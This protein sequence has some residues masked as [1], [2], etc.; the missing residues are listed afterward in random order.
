MDPSGPE[1]HAEAAEQ[2]LALGVGAG[3]G[4]DHD[5]QSLDLVDLVEVDLREDHLLPEPERVVAATVEG[6]VG[7]ALEVAHP[8]QRGG[9]EPVEELVHAVAPQ[10][11]HG[12]DGHPLA[13]LEVRDR[14]LRLRDHRLLAG[15]GRQL[16][17]SRLDDL[18]VLDRLAQPHVEDDLLETRDRH[19]V[20]VAEF[21]HQCGSDLGA[22]PFAQP[23]RHA[24]PCSSVSPQRRH[25]RTPRPS[26]RRRWPIRAGLL[27]R[28]QRSTTL[29]A[30]SDAS[31][32]TMPPCCWTPRGFTWRF[33]RFR[34][35]ITTRSLSV[36]T[37]RILPVLPRSRP[38]MTITVS[39]L[40]SRWT[41]IVTAPRARAR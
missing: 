41:A 30:W 37:R 33:T 28:P 34:R 20:R 32:S 4:A 22:V 2:R 27:H 38:A 19:G 40:R 39:F 36:R 1:R 15:D 18:R 21:A 31:F 6:A 35:S 17:H 29:E 25:T 23:G 11:H 16:L 8:G 10:R 13:Q 14:L 3:G 12:A 26:S 7:H 24:H 9:D 5:R